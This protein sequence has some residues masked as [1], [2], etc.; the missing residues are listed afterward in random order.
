MKR[1]QRSLALRTT[2]R[3]RSATS[4]EDAVN[5]IR[6]Q[7]TRGPEVTFE[8]ELVARSPGDRNDD[9]T[10]GRWHDI[11]VYRTSTDKWVVC[12]HY[13]TRVPSEEPI[14][15]AEVV[16]D[17]HEI[18][19]V[20]QIYQ[21][22]EYVDRTGLRTLSEE[23]R[24]KLKRQLFATYD[25][26]VEDVLTVLRAANVLQESRPSTDEAEEG[27]SREAGAWQGL[28]SRFGLK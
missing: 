16:D 10:G 11:T 19:L 5:N 6:I 2:G 15:D 20:L 28:L 26:Q 17:P 24:N 3:R 9:A 25:R 7:R 23:A 14:V 18:E 12:I 22:N 8:G 1:L 21:P 27:T 13:D 4:A